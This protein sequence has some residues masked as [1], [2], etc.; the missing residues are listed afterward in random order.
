MLIKN[1]HRPW[2]SFGGR[3]NIELFGEVSTCQG[4]IAGDNHIPIEEPRH[5]TRR[6][7]TSHSCMLIGMTN[8][9]HPIETVT[10]SHH[11]CLAIA[12]TVDSLPGFTKTSNASST[13]TL[14]YYSS[15]IALVFTPDTCTSNSA[16]AAAKNSMPNLALSNNTRPHLT[17]SINACT[18]ARTTTQ[19]CNA[20]PGFTNAHNTSSLALTTHTL[21]S[22]C[23]IFTRNARHIWVSRLTIIRI[24]HKKPPLRMSSDFSLLACSS[25]T[26]VSIHHS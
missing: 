4:H 21:S 7:L 24:R 14:A 10:F 17:C 5:A 20:V 18:A 1:H 26:T 8:A 12:G 3:R 19:T 9:K 11:S 22:V 25:R 16:L 6:I 15:P 13:I 23:C 2:L